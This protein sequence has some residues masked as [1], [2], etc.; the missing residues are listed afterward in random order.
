MPIRK[1]T[2]ASPAF[3][4]PKAAKLPIGPNEISGTNNADYLEGTSGDDVILGN[5]GNN[6]L[7]GL[8]GNDTLDGGAGADVMAGGTGDDIYYVD[9]VNDVV[10]EWGGQ[11]IDTVRASLSYHWYTLPTG[12]ENLELIGPD[13]SG[14]DGNELD[15]IITGNDVYNAL[16]GRAGNDTLRGYGGNDIIGGGEGN[17]ILDGGAG[18]DFMHGG[19]GDDTYYVDRWGDDVRE[20]F[21]AGTDTV[22]SRISYTLPE[23]VE[24][25]ELAASATN[26]YA[27]GNSSDNIL[28]G[29]A[30][31]NL[32]VG[33]GGFDTMY[34][35]TGADTFRFLAIGDA[36]LLG[37]DTIRDYSIAEGDRIDLSAI[38]ANLSVAGDQAFVYYG[39]GGMNGIAGEL[40]FNN[41]FLEGDINGDAVAD[42]R[43]QMNA[44]PQT[45][46]DF[47]L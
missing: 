22:Y 8:A 6:S 9:D 46:A 45:G 33:G 24:N 7:Y 30:T 3:A 35:G 31:D 29:N 21:N 43:I 27:I 17:D 36:P 10:W 13:P 34:G 39:S 11:G 18:D 28:R 44:A 38:D 25:L 20:N 5:G 1:V 26:A 14:G 47:I 41:G 15:N 16:D 12:I 4:W 2:F 40:R 37:Y 23:F 19:T 42:F 32:I